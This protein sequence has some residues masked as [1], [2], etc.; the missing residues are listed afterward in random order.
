MD[1]SWS[2]NIIMNINIIVAM[3]AAAVARGETCSNETANIIKYIIE[4]KTY[5]KYNMIPF[6][7][8]LVKK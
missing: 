7:P 6:R 1:S 4:D 3:V 2:D 5:I 8:L